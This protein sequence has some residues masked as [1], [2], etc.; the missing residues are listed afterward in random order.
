MRQT[1]VTALIVWLL[2]SVLGLA[3]GGGVAQSRAQAAPPPAQP[4]PSQVN[5]APPGPQGAQPQP[6]KSAPAL[7]AILRKTIAFLTV[8]Y[9]DGDRPGMA[10]G[11]GFFVYLED[12]RLGEDRGFVY[13]VTNRHM[14]QPEVDGRKV[15]VRNVSVRLNLKSPRAGMESAEVIL[16][17]SGPTRWYFPEDGGVD[18]AAMPWAPD[19]QTFDYE[20]FPASLFATRD[21]VE[22]QGIAEGDAVLFVGF[23]YQFPGQKKAQPIVRQGI[24]AMVPDEQMTTTLQKPGRLFLADAHASRK[25]SGAPMFVNVGGFRGEACLSVAFPTAFWAL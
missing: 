4:A 1:L 21:V 24:L 5:A 20:P 16:P 19:N 23:F 12:K 7:G 11:T 2:A 18:L 9:Q 14:V 15:S 22:S 6:R 17:L 10:R 13:L 8:N 3:A 25:N